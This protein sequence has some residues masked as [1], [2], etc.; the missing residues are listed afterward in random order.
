MS[1]GKKIT[2][3]TEDVAPKRRAAAPKKR[4]S[5]QRSR[6]N[7]FSSRIKSIPIDSSSSPSSE[8]LSELPK[9]TKAREKRFLP[10]EIHPNNDE[11]ARRTPGINSWIASTNDRNHVL[12]E[13]SSASKGSKT[14]ANDIAVRSSTSDRILRNNYDDKFPSFRIKLEKCKDV[15]SGR[16]F[17]PKLG[18]KKDYLSE[19]PITILK[20]MIDIQSL[21]ILKETLL[22]E[23][24]RHVNLEEGQQLIL[25]NLDSFIG[26]PFYIREDPPSSLD[27]SKLV[28]LIPLRN[29]DGPNLKKGS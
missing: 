28:E 6:S 1:R 29:L 18:N 2:K 27:D 15:R 17:T 26:T 25:I 19:N 12:S 9:P 21:N 3:S 7:V 23:I 10:A 5:S 24:E 8:S 16:Q 14:T 20:K 22:P 11:D 13:L 4:V